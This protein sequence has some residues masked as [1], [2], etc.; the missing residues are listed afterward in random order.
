MHHSCGSG[1][2]ASGLV[3]ALEDP[4]NPYTKGQYSFHEAQYG[5]YLG[6]GDRSLGRFT[7]Q[8]DW[9]IKFREDLDRKGELVDMLN[10]NHQDET[11]TDGSDNTIIMFKSCYPNSIVGPA[12][13]S[14]DLD[15]PAVRAAWLDPA[16]G[17]Y[18]NGRWEEGVGGPINYIKA[19]YIGLLDIFRENPDRLFIAV[20]T[21][22]LHYASTNPEDA[23]RARELNDWLCTEWLKGY[24][25]NPNYW[26]HF[27]G[28]PGHEELSEENHA[29]FLNTLRLDY[30][31]PDGG[32]HPNAAGNARL[33]KVFVE[34]F[35]GPT[36]EAWKGG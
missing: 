24:M 26:R 4:A 16:Q 31:S 19:A 25:D 32:S 7:D 11:Y 10:C 30:A 36:Y 17:G 1:W 35:M 15:D 21:P 6:E 5:S 29:Q 28:Q 9:Y 12:D 22:A 3:A 8:H 18:Y 33:V 20:T 13:A 34:K 27:L 2:M 23:R 14:I